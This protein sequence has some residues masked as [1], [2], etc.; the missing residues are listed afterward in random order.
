MIDISHFSIAKVTFEARFGHAYLVWDRSG[1]LWTAAA[2][3]LPNTKLVKAE[4]NSVVFTCDPL[5]ELAVKL[6]RISLT[7]FRA[8]NDLTEFSQTAEKM[9]E[10]A[11]SNLEI[12]EFT[13]LGVRF[14]L[15]KFFDAK[16]LASAA[17]LE[18]SR[19][20]LPKG[21]FF[22]FEVGAPDAATV[23][24]EFAMRIEGE[25]LGVHIRAKA[26]SMT[27]EMDPGYEASQFIN[28]VK[29]EK[30]FVELDIDYYTLAPTP[31]GQLRCR[32]WIENA[33]HMLRRDV[34]RFVWD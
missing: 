15:R 2:K 4:P 34:T 3:Q 20:S 25:K 7:A 31:V 23:N 5:T 19:L 16:A 18:K 12:S 21:K 13:R 11:R 30:H 33:R 10:I 8:K 1:T 6:D 9:V 14:Y 26:E 24:P 32:D 28:P 22:N 17:L 27:V 29:D